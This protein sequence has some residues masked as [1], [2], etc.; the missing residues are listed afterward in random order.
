MEWVGSAR[1]HDLSCDFSPSPGVV[2]DLL[3][4]PAS[5]AALGRSHTCILSQDGTIYTFGTNQYGQCGR[6]YVPPKNAYEGER[7][8]GMRVWLV[9]IARYRGTG[10]NVVCGIMFS[11]T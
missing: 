5:Q 10:F 4:V 7:D 9:G 2:T 6:S 11:C 8:G 3:G 1:S